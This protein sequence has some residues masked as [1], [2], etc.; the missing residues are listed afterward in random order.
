MNDMKTA[1]ELYLSEYTAIRDA[2]ATDPFA[3]S[4]RRA[5]GD[6]RRGRRNGSRGIVR[7]T[8]HGPPAVMARA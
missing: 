7:R 3:E 8:S 5:L 4:G 2:T 6:G 1:F